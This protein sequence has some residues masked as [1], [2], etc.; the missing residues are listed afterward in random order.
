MWSWYCCNFSVRE[1]FQQI[2]IEQI[3]KKLQSKDNWITSLFN[4]REVGFPRQ[5]S[6]S[7][8]RAKSKRTRHFLTI[9]VMKAGVDSMSQV[10]MR[11]GQS[12]L[13]SNVT[14]N[15]CDIKYF[16]LSC[17]ECSRAV[18]GIIS[19]SKVGL[20][21]LVP[22]KEIHVGK[23]KKVRNFDLKD[24]IYCMH[25]LRYIRLTRKEVALKIALLEIQSQNCSEIFTRLGWETFLKCTNA[26]SS[27]CVVF[28]NNFFLVGQC[29]LL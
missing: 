19:V 13:F 8:P 7:A 10:L 1:H 28:K 16:N 12:K 14:F 20:N 5:A 17:I 27:K 3:A 21:L 4:C 18:L 29:K 2:W 23:S 9:Q 22:I 25:F 26:C 11:R 15:W 24:T 6:R